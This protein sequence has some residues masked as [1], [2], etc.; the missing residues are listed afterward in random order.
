MIMPCPRAGAPP[1]CS[2]QSLGSSSGQQPHFSPGPSPPATQPRPSQPIL[3]WDCPA[4]WFPPVPSTASQPRIYQERFPHPTHPR[5]H[6][7]PPCTHAG[8]PP[9]LCCRP[10]TL[11]LPTTIPSHPLAPLFTLGACAIHSQMHPL[12]ACPHAPQG[13]PTA[14]H[15]QVSTS[16]LCLHLG[17]S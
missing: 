14:V 10:Q 4:F 1:A 13:H 15:L 7:L 8:C 16:H 11:S 6:H 3:L 12:R 5:P 2:E 17:L 9:G